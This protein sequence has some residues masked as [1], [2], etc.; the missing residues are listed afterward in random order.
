[1]PFVLMT[2]AWSFYVLVCG[3]GSLYAGV[4][5]DVRA[6]L[7][8]HKEGTGARYTRGRGP[9]RLRGSAVCGTKGDA[10][11]V[12]LRFKSL[13][14]T[15]KVRLLGRKATLAAWVAAIVEGRT[16]TRT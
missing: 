7:A 12:E 9:L 8:Q 5:K 16:S 6:R 14:R 11:S 1:M 10:L 13:P 2:D 15:E 3:D 4:A